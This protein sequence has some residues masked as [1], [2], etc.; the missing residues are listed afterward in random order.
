[1]MPWFG[2]F[3][4]AGRPGTSIRR[5]VVA[6]AAAARD[7]AVP[8]ALPVL[9]CFLV[10]LAVVSPVSA[11]QA[12][13]QRNPPATRRGA[14]DRAT[15]ERQLQERLFATVQ[16]A[17]RLTPQQAARLRTVSQKTDE[18]FTPILRRERELRHQLR[19][20]LGREQRA[21][22]AKVAQLLDGLFAVQRDRLEVAQAE[23]RELALFLTPVQRARYLSIQENLHRRVSELE[24]RDRRDDSGRNRRPPGQE[25][26][27]PDR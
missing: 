18:R 3:A 9:A 15:M 11:I 16:R 13:A 20:E 26:R 4:S 22:D 8:R 2:S 7:S 14:P 1:M 6:V 25:R 27:D 19:S 17:L 23:Q 24:S 21:D 12:Q 5:G 10:A